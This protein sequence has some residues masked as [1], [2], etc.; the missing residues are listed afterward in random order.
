MD[1]TTGSSVQPVDL[2]C[3]TPET[4]RRVLERRGRTK[5]GA[6]CEITCTF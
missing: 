6:D 1:S 4:H 3:G 2:R 5:S